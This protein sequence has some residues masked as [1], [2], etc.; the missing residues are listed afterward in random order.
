MKKLWLFL[1][2]DSRLGMRVGLSFGLLIAL[3][4]AVG[5]VGFRQLRR[6]DADFAK[7]VD[8]RWSKVQLSRRAQDYSNLN[9]RINTQMVLVEDE[10]TIKSLMAQRAENSDKISAL[11]ET[12]Q[13]KIESLE[14]QQL[15]SAIE[16][17]RS[18]YLTEYKAA[19]RLLT[20][21]KNPAAARALM[22]NQAMPR[23]IEYH[24][25]W[26]AYVDYQGRQMDLAQQG[27]AASA[28]ATRKTT[29]LLIA[30]AVI[31]AFTIGIFVTRNITWHMKMRKRDEQA[32]RHAHEDLEAKVQSRTTELANVNDALEAENTER[33][34]IEA[35]LRESEERYRELFEN[36]NDII[37]THDLQGNYT[38]VNKACEKIIGYTSA[39]A[40]GMNMAQVV[41]P[42]YLDEARQLLARKT[43]G[44]APSAYE[45][46]IVANDGHRVMLEVNSRLTYED[47][48]P[49]G[50][51]GMARDITERKRAEAERQVITEIVQGVVSTSNLDELLALTHNSIRKLLYAENCF[52]TLYDPASDL[53]HF[54]FWADKFDPIPEPRPIGTNFSSYVLKTSQPIMLTEAT[55]KRMYEQGEIELSGTDSASWLGV[56]LRTPSGTI[57]V[58]VVQHYE[59]AA[60]Y[61]QRDLEFLSAVGNQIALAIE[62][63]RG[64]RELEQARD[65]A[66]E[67]ARL[68][69]EFLANM[70]HEIR[71]PMNGVVGMTGILLDSDLDADQRECAETIRSSADAL[72]TIINDILDFSKIEAGKLEFEAVDFDLRNAVEE[73]IELLAE[74][75]REKELEFASLIY[76]DVPTALR[77]DPGRL[78]QVL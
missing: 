73:T 78:R 56:P 58:L 49:T 11:L 15:L 75:A 77:G 62:R 48:K 53:M 55:K 16:E 44:K 42:E 34:Q 20:V 41:A 64:E 61:T 36:A 45:V 4:L 2:N 68:K 13:D 31:F 30:F 22:V 50:V 52:V 12:L 23:M 47:G 38:S 39:E 72:L 24:Q 51:Q 65:A 26:D 7:M 60:A 8:Q 57:G 59:E 54:E 37:Y 70:S 74:K 29:V 71:T 76:G 3:M 19:M 1:A 25:A 9:S 43:T 40:L 66:L 5:W 33:K 32:L 63:K 18:L 46:E 6:V 28:T 67:S 35:S 17:K 69:S 10:T 14:E 21:A 27:D